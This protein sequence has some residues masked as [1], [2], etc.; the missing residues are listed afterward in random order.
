MRLLTICIALVVISAMMFS[1]KKDESIVNP[2]TTVKDSTITIFQASFTAGAHPTSGIVKLAKDANGKKF[3]I[4]DNFKTDSGPDLRI[5][6]SDDLKATNYTEISNK[7]INGSYQLTVDAS[8]DT[9]KKRKVLVWC[10][11]FSVLFGSADL[12]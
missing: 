8:I 6:L 3:L 9:E 7:V 2:P 11:Q 10:K 5:Y 4:F 1:C 12:K